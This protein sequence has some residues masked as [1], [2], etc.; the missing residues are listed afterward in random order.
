VIGTVSSDAKV[1]YAR[2]NG[3]EHVIVTSREDFE[4]RIAE[5]TE[6]RGVDVCFDG[7]GEDVFL[8]SFNC[9]RKYGMMVSYGQSSG[10]VAPLDIVLL[11]HKGHYLTKF[12]GSTY[13][14]NTDEYQKRAREVVQ[15]IE[16]GMIERGHHVVYPLAEVARAHRDLE[17]RRT[18]G[19]LVL[20]P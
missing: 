20:V 5:I 17:E 12:S 8:K 7:V 6:G 2:H 11:Q 9:I 14:A 10:M 15:A 3:C 4:K 18:T 16:D 19:S 1:D 13:N